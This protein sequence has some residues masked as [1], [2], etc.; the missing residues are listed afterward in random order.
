M[1]G[2]VAV[3]TDSTACLGRDL[4]SGLGIRVVPLR[5]VLAGH[6]HDETSAAGI[7]V[8]DALRR[9][10]ALTT[11]RPAP[12]LFSRVYA[13]AA[14]AGAPGIVSVHLSGRMSGTV[15]A[16]RLAAASAAMP[17]L[18]VDTRTVGA[19]L[20]FAVLA[21]AAAARSGR[22]LGEVAAAATRRSARLNSLFCLGSLD[23][24][25]RG[26]RDGGG[27]GPAPTTLADP[28]L[29][30]TAQADAALAATTLSVKQ[31]MRIVDGR[32]VPFEKV[33]TMAR[34]VARLEQLAAEFAAKFAAAGAPVDVAV[35][36]VANSERAAQLAGRLRTRIPSL[37]ALH[38]SE[39]GPV[40]AVHT[41][42]D[43]LGVVVAPE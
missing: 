17:V 3:V 4:G 18:V 21:A 2:P 14:A 9:G 1:A 39:A 42:P 27:A 12:Q 29:A 31:L 32:I 13:E 15:D 5:V 37:R 35:Q 6:A 11:S 19:G 34:A 40:I 23:Q 10:I 22:T 28:A 16:A 41:G 36:H 38:V 43:M 8:S 20:G 7:D 30:G 24:L 33:R 26:G 25:R